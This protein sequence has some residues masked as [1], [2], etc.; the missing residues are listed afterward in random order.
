MRLLAE[1]LLVQTTGDRPYGEFPML[2]PPRSPFPCPW[3]PGHPMGMSAPPGLP[4]LDQG[5]GRGA[6]VTLARPPAHRL[7]CSDQGL[8]VLTVRPPAAMGKRAPDR[9]PLVSRGPTGRPWD[10]R[11]EAPS[12]ISHIAAPAAKPRT[13][14]GISPSAGAGALAGEGPARPC[15]GS[16][17][18]GQLDGGALG[19]LL[20]SGAPD[21]PG[22]SASRRT[23]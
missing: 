22:I 19:L 7:G 4:G 6:G 15:V 1:T 17:A 14:A 13:R 11:A 10:P 12:A 16:G 21:A 8:R 18:G 9:R 5:T 2:P 23:A 20:R 3:F